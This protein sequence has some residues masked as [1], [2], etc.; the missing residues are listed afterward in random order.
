MNMHIVFLIY[1]LNVVQCIVTYYNETF[2]LAKYTYIEFLRSSVKLLESEYEPGSISAFLELKG[3]KRVSNLNELKD[4]RGYNDVWDLNG[5]E[6]RDSFSLSES[7]D[8]HTTD[9]YDL[10][11][12]SDPTNQQFK[13]YI[14]A[15]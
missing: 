9:R 3:I 12:F 6:K 8:I 14:K 2:I 4:K 10:L 15:M 5:G 7:D 13:N 1:L 11:M